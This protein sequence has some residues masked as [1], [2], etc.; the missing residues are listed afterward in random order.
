PALVIFT[1][2]SRN[3][4]NSELPLPRVR[5]MYDSSA[6]TVPFVAVSTVRCCRA[7]AEGRSSAALASQTD[8][9]RLR[10]TNTMIPILERNASVA[11][12]E[13]ARTGSMAYVVGG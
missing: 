9:S 5:L 6:T 4:S 3:W 1:R 8:V 12:L 7:A 13:N 11:H 10:F 2:K